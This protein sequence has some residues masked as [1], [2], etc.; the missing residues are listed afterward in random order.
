MSAQLELAIES[1]LVTTRPLLLVGATGNA[2]RQ[3]GEDIARRLGYRYYEFYCTE[4][5]TSQDLIYT[6]DQTRR[7]ADA[8]LGRIAEWSTY[9]EPGVLWWALD[10]ESA[11]RRGAPP[12]QTP[13]LLAID[14][15]SSNNIMRNA[16]GPA[17]VAIH[18]LD[19]LEPEAIEPLFF[20]NGDFLK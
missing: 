18:N 5:T 14:P 10:A 9:I 2:R 15:N 6:L 11:R 13:G 1:A 20:R 17:V 8:Q 7:L 12:D 3:T 4:R 16:E 19:R